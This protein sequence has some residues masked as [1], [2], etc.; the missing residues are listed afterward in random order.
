MYHWRTAAGEDC[1][2]LLIA[3]G[4]EGENF[5]RLMEREVA[6]VKSL[7]ENVGSGYC[8]ESERLGEGVLKIP[9][10]T[11]TFEVGY[12]SEQNL[13]PYPLM[14]AWPFTTFFPSCCTNETDVDDELRIGFATRR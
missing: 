5:L 11:S 6:H 3:G 1:A 10:Y 8:R 7:I 12:D 13:F 4:D 14:G 2:D 9:R